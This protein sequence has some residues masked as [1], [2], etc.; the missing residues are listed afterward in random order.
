M[1]IL[2]NSASVVMTTSAAD[3][4]VPGY[5]TAERIALTTN[6]TGGSYSWSMVGPEDSSLVRAALT[7]PTGPFS[8][9]IPDVSGVY[10][11]GCTVD[12]STTYVLRVTVTQVATST[13]TEAL[14]LSPLRDEQVTA[15]ALG[16]ALYDSSSV[17]GPAYKTPDGAVHPLGV[18][19]S[20][21]VVGGLPA[22][23]YVP[24]YQA[25]S[26]S[27][28]WQ[29]SGGLTVTSFAPA[30]SLYECSQSVI[31]PSFTASY[32]LAPTTALLSNNANGES[33]DVH[34]TPT[35]FASSQTYQKTTPNQSVTWT[36]TTSNGNRTCSA[37]WSQRSYAGVVAS[38]ASLATLIS[39]ATY[40]SLGTA[41]AFSFTL[42]DDGTHK[43]QFSYPARY[44]APATVKDRATGFGIGYV[45]LGAFSRTNAQ[46]FAESYNQYEFVS[47]FNTTI[48][49]D[50]T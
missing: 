1:G 28:V 23:G 21:L 7:M 38:G 14:R 10:T 48:T 25:S 13:S 6:P 50:V 19:G 2:A 20:G 18:G 44:G 33:K 4:A 9:F 35:A 12:L 30:V 15:P 39:A 49:V 41:R 5:L 17:G 32:N 37:T 26:S 31:N 8:S 3:D 47:T 45:L 34:A 42:T 27:A 24:T 16:L 22:D 46:G 36:L 29:P 43:G 40:T 11:I